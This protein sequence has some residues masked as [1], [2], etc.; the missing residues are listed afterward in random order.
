MMNRP[1][2]ALVTVGWLVACTD[3][4]LPAAGGASVADSA[5]QVM[6]GMKT[7]LHEGGLRRA[8]VL[9]D[10]AYFY[11]NHT[12]LELRG[13]SAE[14]YTSTGATDGHLNAKIA[15]V[16][17]QSQAMEAFGDVILVSVDGSRLTSP[18]LRYDP[19]LDQIRGDSAFTLTRPEGRNVSGIGFTTT[20][21]MTSIRI[22]RT[23]RGSAGTVEI[24][25]P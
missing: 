10:S 18:Q 24:P 1:W 4:S 13:V 25:P 20:P 8:L 7:F 22:D 11:D 17:T 23:I 9:A 16:H 15:T 14:F 12:R 21:S 19:S 3:T 6:V 5:D 2:F